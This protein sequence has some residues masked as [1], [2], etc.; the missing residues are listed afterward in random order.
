MHTYVYTHD[1][2]LMEEANDTILKNFISMIN[3]KT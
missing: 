2:V 1:H 3:L